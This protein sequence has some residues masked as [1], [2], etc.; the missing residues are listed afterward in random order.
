MKKKKE[1]QKHIPMRMC[2]VTHER[3][4]K[5]E[6]IRFVRI[7]DKVVIDPKGKMRGRGANMKMDVEIFDKAVKKGL[8]EKALKLHR[9]LKEEEVGKL[10]EIF[11]KTVEDK[12][13]RK[14]DK[15]V[16]IRVGKDTLEKVQKS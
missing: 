10:R 1:R 12:R 6:L 14:T 8:I 3:L 13:F 5:A 9:K 11:I 2:I 7:D 16:V 15:V 4:P